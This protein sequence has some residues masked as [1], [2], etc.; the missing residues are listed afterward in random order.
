MSFFIIIQKSLK[1]GFLPTNTKNPSANEL[2]NDLKPYSEIYLLNSLEDAKKVAELF[3]HAPIVPKVGGAYGLIAEVK[4]EFTDI[5][6]LHTTDASLIYNNWVDSQH[7]K[8]FKKEDQGN[9]YQCVI[10]SPAQIKSISQTFI[11]DNA[12]AFNFNLEDTQFLE[13]PSRC[14]IL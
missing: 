12:K 5:P 3:F 9:N 2:L 8:Y 11:P 10:V 7:L 1:S 14:L 4:V 13:R 6:T